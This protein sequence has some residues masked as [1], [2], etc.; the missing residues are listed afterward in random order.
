VKPVVSPVLELRI[1]GALQVAAG[2]VFGA[3]ATVLDDHHLAALFSALV[4]AGVFGVLMYLTA[5][6]R[7]MAKAVGAASPLDA[8]PARE[9]TGAT[10]W[11]QVRTVSVLV[12]AEVVLAVLFAMPALLAGIVLGNGVAV[13][14]GA[15]WMNDWQTL[16]SVRL[17]R[18]PRYRFK[19]AGRWGW[20]RG[21]GSM[22]GQDYYLL[23]DT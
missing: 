9:A 7:L 23:P 14:L 3:V 21:A 18:E 12:A 15:R 4:G 22:D 20:G 6:R 17:V 13:L 11:R 2:V 1:M 5:F 8:A 16:H 10:W 19:R